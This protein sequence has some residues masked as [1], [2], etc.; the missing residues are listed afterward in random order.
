MTVILRYALYLPWAKVW[1][2]GQ[3]LDEAGR[4]IGVTWCR[5]YGEA[6]KLPGVKSARAMA[7]RVADVW[8][9]DVDVINGAGARIWRAIG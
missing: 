4:V 6:L 7:R 2:K 8:A 9:V 5:E 1:L 3:Y